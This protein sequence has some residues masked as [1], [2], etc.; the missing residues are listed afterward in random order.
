MYYKTVKSLNL[1]I[2]IT[3]VFITV[4]EVMFIHG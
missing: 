1:V 3:L 4:L 2:K